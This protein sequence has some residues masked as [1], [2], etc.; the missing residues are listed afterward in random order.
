MKESREGNK[1]RDNDN[2]ER[3]ETDK[4]SGVAMGQLE[5]V[6]YLRG[7]AIFHWTEQRSLGVTI[8]S[9]RQ[10]AASLTVCQHFH[11]I[12]RKARNCNKEGGS[13]GSKRDEVGNQRNQERGRYIYI[14]YMCIDL[15][16]SMHV[17]L[18]E[19]GCKAIYEVLLYSR[20]TK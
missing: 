10:P 13:V 17:C 7:A 2:R 20:T 19:R 12:C 6:V 14:N 9:N 16:I 8:L 4:Y 1:D 5:G 11:G 15:C 3:N 18:N